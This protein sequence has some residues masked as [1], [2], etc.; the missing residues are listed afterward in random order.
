MRITYS[1][2]FLS[3]VPYIYVGLPVKQGYLFVANIIG[4]IL[5]GEMITFYLK[6]IAIRKKPFSFMITLVHSERFTEGW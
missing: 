4:K 5:T 6:W 3:R 2:M 1:D